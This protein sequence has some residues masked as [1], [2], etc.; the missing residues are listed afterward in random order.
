MIINPSNDIWLQ[1][2]SAATTVVGCTG[3]V[4]VAFENGDFPSGNFQMCPQ[5]WFLILML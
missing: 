2:S 3:M 5:D 1:G 4:T